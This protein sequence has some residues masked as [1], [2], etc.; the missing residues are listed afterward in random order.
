[1][2]IYNRWQEE[3]SDYSK[4]EMTK[5]SDILPA[6]SGLA[7]KVADITCDLYLAGIWKNDLVKGL[8]WRT[9]RGRRLFPYRAPTWSWFSIAGEIWLSRPEHIDI[10][11]RSYEPPKIKS[12]MKFVR[13]EL[14]GEDPFHRL[15]L[16]SSLTLLGMIEQARE[17]INGPHEYC[18]ILE[19]RGRARVFIENQN[20]DPDFDPGYKHRLDFGLHSSKG[21]DIWYFPVEMVSGYLDRKDYIMA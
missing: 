16:S 7:H 14:L 21:L 4:R 19:L 15:R 11:V 9:W 6:L 13:A 12:V 5:E 2:Q 1:M 3:V 8:L 10:I 17:L 20:F 18:D